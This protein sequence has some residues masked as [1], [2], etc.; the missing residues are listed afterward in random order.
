MKETK[1]LMGMP[2]TV[3]ICDASA[4]QKDIATV[5]A[6]FDYVDKT[7]ST[8]KPDS[9]ITKIN[10]GLV[11]PENFSKDMKT[12]FELSKE[13]K[14]ETDGY[15]DI[16]N[17]QG[18]YDPSGLV[19]GWAIFNA[20]KI[21]KNLGFKHFYVEAG[22]DIQV[23]GKNH[24]NMAWKVGIKNPFNVKEIVKTVYSKNNEGIATSGSYQRGSHIYNPK[25]RKQELAEIIS[26]TVIGTNIYQADR[27]ATAAFA[28]GR[29]GIHFIEKLPGFEA[30]MIDHKGIAT[31]TSG[32]KNFTADDN[33]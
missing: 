8:Y 9:E 11:L 29:Y 16:V 20:A 22:G 5:F 21:L 32:F 31:M 23:E 26:L 2:V 18:I 12:V 33:P 14:Q 30:Y 27:F 17:N 3:E 6:Y 19:K 7:F 13:T 28:M 10:N 24:Q 1:I 15:F 4:T 25:N